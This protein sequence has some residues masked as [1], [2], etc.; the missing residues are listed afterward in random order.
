MKYIIFLSLLLSIKI[1][2]SA[3]QTPKIDDALLLD[4]YQNQ[5]FAEAADYLK[6]NYPEPVQ[7]VKALGQLAYTSNMAGRLTDA[8]KYYQ[9]IYE[10]D[11]SGLAIL[12]NLG[13][14]NLRRGNN[15]KAEIYY[16]RI[17]ARDTTNFMVYKQLAKL[18]GDK[19]DIPNKIV[20]LQKANIL[21][22]T[23]PDVASDLS[24]LYVNIKLTQQ[25]EK[26]LGKAIDADPENIVLLNSLLKLQYAQKKWMETLST[27]DK[28]IVAG[29]QSGPVLTKI[30][31]AYYN[32]KNYECALAALLLID[33]LSQ[34]E[35][36]FYFTALTYKA[37][38]DQKMA[39]AYLEQAISDGITPNAGAYYGEI[40]DSNEKL[41]RYKKAVLSYQK[42]LQ[43]AEDPMMYYSL[44]NVYDSNLKDKKNAVKYYRKYL[45]G[46]PPVAKQQA[47]IDYSKSRIASL[48]Q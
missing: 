12:F 11:S 19:N 8:E 45:A 35:S 2:A 20:Y 41:K 44:A 40:A 30:G 33:K 42:S 36:S 16:K 18:S 9:R 17:A 22:P 46:K 38:K 48:G 21:N 3:Q 25:A 29:D 13:N 26:V 7:S 31:V 15:A 47:Y 28:L 6:Q 4:Y 32:T 24:D 27:G 39:I 14:I 10:M 23:E 1:S 43:F 37:L 5:R 34:N